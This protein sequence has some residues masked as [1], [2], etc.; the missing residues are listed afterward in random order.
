[1]KKKRFSKPKPVCWF[2]IPASD[3]RRARDFYHALFG[4]EFQEFLSFQADYWTLQT[5][6]PELSGAIYRSNQV[7]VSGGVILYI[8]VDDLPATIRHALQ[9]DGQLIRPQAMITSNTGRHALIRDTEGN[10]LGLWG[11]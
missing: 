10:V 2:E 3:T 5:E 4:W 11:K 6:A 8:R 9:L 1:M 7:P